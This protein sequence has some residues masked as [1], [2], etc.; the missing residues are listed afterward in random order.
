[1]SDDP[2]TYRPPPP[3]RRFAPGLVL[4]AVVVAV[5]AGTVVVSHRVRLRRE[6]EARTAEADKGRLV[7]PGHLERSPEQVTLRLPGEIHGYTETPVY[8]KVAGYLQ[9][10]AVDKGDRVTAGQVLAVLESPELDQQV[11]NAQANAD[12]KRATDRRF[13]ALRTSG[14]VSQ[15]DADQSRAD[16]L[17]AEATLK[18]LQAL[19]EY[20]KI[21]AEFDGVV[22]ARYADPGTL[23]PQATGGGIGASTPILAMTTLSP[24]RVYVDLPQAEARYVRDG[25]QAVVTVSEYGGRRFGGAVTRHPQALASATRTMLVEVDL[26]NDDRALLP[27]MYAQVEITLTGRTSAVRVPDDV[28]IFR[29]GKTWVPVIDGEHLRVVEVHLGYD[30]GRLS[31][32]TDG[33]TGD[34]RLAM[35]VGQT[36]KDGELVRVQERPDAAQ[37]K[38]GAT[39]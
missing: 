8:A 35:N 29:D 16:T 5:A 10:I 9:T 24:L 3:G 26:T 27:G 18:Q 25:D 34:E 31:E 38:P 12:L 21:T 37:A 7:S 17:S 11:R 22:T 1:M 39:H 23:I 13:A 20:L 30:D 28:L 15:Q 33:L 19:H 14:V 6:A 2:K 32:V 4:A 36:A